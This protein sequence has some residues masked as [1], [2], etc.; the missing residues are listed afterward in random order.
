MRC[1]LYAR[2]ST[3]DRQDPETQLLALRQYAAARGWEVV[4]EYVDR[5]SAV[6]LRGRV[7][8]KEV[9]GLAARRRIDAILVARLDRAF[10]SMVHLTTT[11]E[12]LRAS[13]VALVSLSEPWVNTAESSPMADLVRNILGSVAEFERGLISERVRAGMARAKK[14]G[15][16][17]GRP[18]A[19]KRDGK[20]EQVG[21]ILHAIRTG[22][23]SQRE[24]ARTLGVGRA[25]I[26][27]LLAARKGYANAAPLSL[28][29]QPVPL[30]AVAGS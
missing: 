9:L 12:Q 21:A 11:I 19:L 17:V 8:W 3:L 18:A 13:G 7:A 30:A 23:M 20:A 24:A 5:S 27:R 28:D 10:R 15:A 25:T 14:Q 1:S 6:N 22:A 16:P 2:C 29:N 26:Q 4:G